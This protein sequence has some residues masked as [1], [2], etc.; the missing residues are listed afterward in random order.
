[1]NKRIIMLILSSVI[2]FIAIFSYYAYANNAVNS[3]DTKLINNVVD[4][5]QNLVLAHRHSISFDDF[6]N[7]ISPFV[8]SYYR[9]SY[10]E[11]LERLYNG[12][13]NLAVSVQI[14]LYEYISKVYSSKDEKYKYI[15]AKIPEEGVIGQA[16]KL[17]KFKEENGEWR[18]IF[19]SYHILS[20]GM[21]ELRKDDKKF[22]N[23]NG[24]SIEYES[25]KII[26]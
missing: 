4:I 14:P 10:F 16:A 22:T 6:R 15:Y 25:I 12:G 13:G 8:H 3:I 2:I 7:K 20:D 9:D 17:Y 24:T 23:H 21:K 19:V 18:I 26:E 5:E 1:M 11:G